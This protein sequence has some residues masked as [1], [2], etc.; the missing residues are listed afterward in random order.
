VPAALLSAFASQDVLARQRRCVVFQRTARTV[1][2]CVEYVSVM[3]RVN[4]TL[5]LFVL[6]RCTVN[7]VLEELDYVNAKRTAFARM[8]QCVAVMYTV[9]T[10]LVGLVNA[11]A[12]STALVRLA[13]F[14]W[15]PFRR[16]IALTDVAI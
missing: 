1:A 2:D 9:D 10:V 4:D 3:T 16:S 12:A 7:T 13:L 15:N 14:V 5:I 8:V 11:N 6:H